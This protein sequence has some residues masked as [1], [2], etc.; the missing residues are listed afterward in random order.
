[1]ARL[2]DNSNLMRANKAKQDEFY[3]QLPDVEDELRHYR[4]HFKNKVVLC[5]C[6]DPFES[7]FFRYFCL[8]FN[9]L[10]LKR[11][12]ATC[13][14]GS[15]IAGQQL[16]LFDVVDG[17]QPGT[18]YK[19]I[20]TTV[21]D[22]TGDGM[23]KMDDVAEL[24]KVGEN[25]LSVLDGDGDF[26]SDECLA[27]MDEADIVVTNPPF[28]LF[29]DYVAELVKRDKQFLII[30]NKN[31]ITYKEI[32]PLIRDGKMWV[33][34][35]PM[36]KEFYFHVPD[37]YAQWLIEQGRDRSIVKHNGELVARASAIWFTNMHIR[38]QDDEML[39]WKRYDP[40]VYP[41]YD[42]YDAI[43]VSKTDDIPCD[44]AGVMGVPITFL[45]KHNPSQF[46][47]LG[48]TESEGKGLSAGIW[49]ASSG[50]AQPLVNGI[51]KYKRIFI[52]NLHP[53]ETE[54]IA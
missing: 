51:R 47:I 19:A 16:S 36:S 6:D 10:K 28:S 13:Y 5:N 33:G 40:E 11:L 18:P 39:L 14:A 35:M 24:F 8:N 34:M 25:E 26:R 49:D 22:A 43:E 53:E 1:M 44:Y 20:V 54:V 7:A 31:A 38:R 52:R 2:A 32:F 3:T 23:V 15:P 21:R 50:V 4:K 48:C 42:N 17:A 41:R 37:E 30:G 29:R 45:A 9:K 12:I 27:L 46:D